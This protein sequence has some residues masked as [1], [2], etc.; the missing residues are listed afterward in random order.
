MQSL[1][2]TVSREVLAGFFFGACALVAVLMVFVSVE[3]EVF[4]ATESAIVR[5]SQE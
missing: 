3:R 2:S 1:T 5:Y 4:S